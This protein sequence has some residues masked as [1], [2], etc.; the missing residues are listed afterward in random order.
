MK[1]NELA[2][3]SRVNPETIRM[4]RN[5]GLLSPQRGENGY[6]EY[7]WDDFQNLLY[8]RKLRGL[9]IPLSSIAK[10]YS[11][12]DVD[13]IVA[14]FQGVYDGLSAQIDELSRQRLMLQ[15]TMEH[16]LSYRKNLD[17]VIP[18]H[19]PDDRL[20]LPFD[21]SL[22]GKLPGEWLD[23][24]DLFTQGLRIPEELLRGSALPERVPVRLT[25]GTYRLLLNSHGVEVPRDAVCLPEGLYLT[26]KVE[27]RGN[28]IEGRQLQPLVDYARAHSYALTGES[29]AFLF[30]VSRD[31]EGLCFTYRLRARVE[32]EQ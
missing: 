19:V 8:I 18:I 22:E 26:A 30:R 2:K 27:R 13:D 6:F 15:V 23:N 11:D 9:N 17:G 4:Y 25:L 5:K 16:Y 10:T 31:R 3:L 20:D 28:Y 12:G 24:I 7:S 14:D 32:D 21:G 1:I 29:T